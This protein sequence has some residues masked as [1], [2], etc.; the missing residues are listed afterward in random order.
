MIRL[1][2]FA[3][4]WGLAN[5]SPFCMKLETYLRMAQLPFESCTRADPRSAPKGKLPYIEDGEYLVGDSG[6]AIEH[7]IARYGDTLDQ[8]L[9]AVERA[10]AAAFRRLIEEHLYWVLVYSRWIVADNWPL[11]RRAYFGNLPLGVGHAVSALA[12][13]Q[14]RWAL[15]LQGLGRHTPQEIFAL[16]NK[17]ISAISDFLGAK[18]FF[19]GEQPASID[20]TVYAFIANIILAPI[21]SPLKAHAARLQNLQNYCAHMQRRYFSK[22]PG[23][24][25]TFTA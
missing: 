4:A 18:P 5:A 7:I 10:T 20:A 9:T 8:H 11:T 23:A 3:P 24:A 15:H 1:H 21:E 2:Q 22:P 14:V 25:T 19:L 6:F 13:L 12:R 16:G 17:D